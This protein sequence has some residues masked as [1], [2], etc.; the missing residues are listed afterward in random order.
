LENS[1][2]ELDIM[3]PYALLGTD[4]PM[5]AFGGSPEVNQRVSLQGLHPGGTVEVQRV[6]IARRIGISRTRERAAPTPATATTHGS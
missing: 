2:R 3:G 4:E 1:L 6:I 5:A